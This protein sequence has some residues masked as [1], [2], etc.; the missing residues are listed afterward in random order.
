MT[1]PQKM[2]IYMIL[3]A[4]GMERGE[5]IGFYTDVFKARADFEAISDVGSR[6]SASLTAFLITYK[7]QKGGALIELAELGRK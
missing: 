1:N 6:W 7:V 3:G 5:P 2:Q 4:K